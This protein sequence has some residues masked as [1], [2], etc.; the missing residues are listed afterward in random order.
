MQRGRR[1][2]NVPSVRAYLESLDD[3]RAEIWANTPDGLKHREEK[4]KER[5]NQIQQKA[6]MT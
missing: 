4:R 6:T 1:L 3:R 5:E 2:F